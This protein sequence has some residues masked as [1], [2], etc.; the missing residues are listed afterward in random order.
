MSSI[1]CQL[2]MAY[3]NY[4]LIKTIEVLEETGPIFLFC[5]ILLMCMFQECSVQ[6]QLL[7]HNLY[8]IMNNATLLKVNQ[9]EKNPVLHS[10]FW[11]CFCMLFIC[12]DE[13]R[14]PGYHFVSFQSYTSHFRQVLASSEG[15]VVKLLFTIFLN[16]IE[17]C[18]QTYSSAI[19][20][21][22]RQHRKARKNNY[23]L[24]RFEG[25]GSKIKP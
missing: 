7:M 8:S 25:F 15:N 13:H 14:P 17:T 22:A 10:C 1:S 2:L 4:F 18:K 9:S 20:S 11:Q 24:L 16:T 5:F 19:F 21:G 6:N 12:C 3:F 23:P